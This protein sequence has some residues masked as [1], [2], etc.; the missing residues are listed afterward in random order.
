MRARLLA[1]DPPMAW[2]ATTRILELIREAASGN[3]N[4][5]C[6]ISTSSPTYDSVRLGAVFQQVAPAERPDDG[7]DR[8]VVAT[9][10][11]Q[12]FIDIYQLHS[13]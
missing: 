10:S 6:D 13:F 1:H 5:R 8:G 9:S 3:S 12:T 11:I 4:Q 7:L 2:K